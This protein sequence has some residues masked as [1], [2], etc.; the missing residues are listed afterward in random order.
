M[1]YEHPTNRAMGMPDVLTPDDRVSITDLPPEVIDQICSRLFDEHAINVNV[2]RRW[3]GSRSQRLMRGFPTAISRLSGLMQTSRLFRERAQE[4]IGREGLFYANAM[5]FVDL[6]LALGPANTQLI[7]R[8]QIQCFYADKMLDEDVWPELHSML[9]LHLPN[10]EELEVWSWSQGPAYSDAEAGPAYQ[11]LTREQQ[12]FYGLMKFAAFLKH[13]NLKRVIACAENER[14]SSDGWPQVRT[15]VILDTGEK[16][17]TWRSVLQESH[18]PHDTLQVLSKDRVLNATLI[19]KT[20]KVDLAQ[21]PL[22]TLILEPQA[23][24]TEATLSTSEEHIQQG[25]P[26]RGNDELIDFCEELDSLS[27]LNKPDLMQTLVAKWERTLLENQQLTRERDEYKMKSEDLES[28]SAEM[29]LQLK[30]LQQQVTHDRDDLDWQIDELRRK[31]Q[32]LERLERRVEYQDQ[33]WTDFCEA[34]EMLHDNQLSE[35]IVSDE[36]DIRGPECLDKADL[37]QTIVNDRDKSFIAKEDSEGKQKEA[38]GRI[39]GLE[40]N[41]QYTQEGVD[42]LKDGL[43]RS[44]QENKETNDLYYE[45]YN[46]KE[47]LAY[48]NGM[49]QG[50]TRTFKR[51]VHRLEQE[52]DDWADA[53]GAIE[54]LY[55]G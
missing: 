46:E 50:R 18:A 52:K 53:R 1:L 9:K 30:R 20:K 28:G 32:R 51:M 31:V 11:N 2:R 13:P 17:R 48:E 24:K 33:D 44:K 19:R 26:W 43:E 14:T 42:N 37:I 7:K 40:W 22:K 3:M 29:R 27:Q 23:G 35:W 15:S 41:L 12:D 21:T 39:R 4:C 38:D 25:W 49:L 8:L 34:I 45:A 5:N 10:L 54:T 36:S 6:P 16:R 47:W 55:D